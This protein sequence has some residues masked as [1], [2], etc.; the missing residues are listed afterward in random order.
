MSDD[1][2]PSPAPPSPA[3]SSGAALL[4][5]G[6]GKRS[7]AEFL[8][9]LREHGVEFL[10]D[11]RS[12]P[13]SKFK[14]EFNK[15]PLAAALR[16]A[17]IRYVFMGDAL[18][19]RPGAPECLTD[20]EV[21]YAK[22]RQQPFF[23][24]GLARLRKAYEQGR[25]VA[26]MCGEERPE[27][28]HRSRLIGAA[29]DALGLP[30]RHVD[31]NGRLLTQTQVMDRLTGGQLAL[32]VGAE[33]IAAAPPDAEPEPGAWAT[34]IPAA[35]FRAGPGES[36]ASATP[37][38]VSAAEESSAGPPPEPVDPARARVVLKQT[39]GFSGFLPL[40]AEVIE[41]LLA[42]RDTL[43]VMPTGGGKS[44]CY[45]L[46]AL[47]FDGLTVVVSPLI[48]LMQDQVRQLH[49]LGVPAAFLNSS[50]ARAEYGAIARQVRRGEARILYVAPETLLRPD[51]LELLAHGRLACFAVDEAHC[52]S[53]WGHDFRPEYRELQAV[54]RRFPRAVCVALTATATRRVRED[55]RR[56]LD[57]PE[58]GEFVASFNRANLSLAVLPR[59]D[60]LGQVLAFLEAHRQQAGIIYCATRKQVDRLAAELQERQWPALPYHAGLDPETRRRNQEQFVRA[61]DAVMVATIAFGMGINKS[62]VR[63]VLH[64]NLPK[65]LES[66]YQEIGRAGRD[67][68]PADCLLLH[69]RRDAI[70][71]RR[72]IDE[73]AAS[74][75]AGRQA[76]LEA[77]IR[78]AETTQCRRVPL[79]AYFGETHPGRCEHCDNCRSEAAPVETTDVTEAAQKFLSCV[80]RTGERFGAA[81]LIDVL[82]GSRSQRV[83]DRGHDRLSTYGIGKD[84]SATAWRELARQFI[85]QG[86]LEQDLQHG[87]LR[88]TE[89]A[90]EV[91]RGAPVRARVPTE[92][93]PTPSRR[94]AALPGH[95]AELFA[96]LR[97]LRRELADAAN[98]PPY[99]IFTDRA[100]VEMAARYPRTEAQFL[101]INGVGQAKLAH[102]GETF[103]RA[104]REYCEPRGLAPRG[105]EPP[106][107]APP[108]PSERTVWRTGEKRRQEMV[109]EQLAAGRTVTEIATELGI[110][111]ATVLKHLGA[112]LAEGHTLDPAPLWRSSPLPVTE[113]HRVLAA[114]AELGAE[115]LAPVREALGGRVSYDDLHLLRCYWLAGGTGE[116]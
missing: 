39:F 88:L 74:E 38:A 99:I 43:V 15:E 109:G 92:A 45:Q 107:P 75:A 101:E 93:A 81:H 62:N 35:E 78:Y 34:A 116:E 104:I 42:R 7:G 106:A 112:W 44:L 84:L 67:G 59:R 36:P 103:L 69:S 68:L 14:P 48:A 19:G 82:R 37:P 53:E 56:L 61:D 16:A 87:G 89:K 13:C 66:Y 73:G 70:T 80:R 108:P 50:L 20:G 51:T 79:L 40:Q 6:Y 54:R 47:L 77:M 23:Q 100:L 114:F 8:A 28:C 41:R 105:A 29:L 9:L 83:L 64:F 76:R 96:R 2:R 46:P 60:G 71:I 97:Q 102:Y 98:L 90:W 10:L 21:D 22:V 32:P 63:F 115:R 24:A 94:A 55:I 12:A 18:G 5:V 4:T 95:D 110:K 26:L 86:L 111:P 85:E 72:F 31:E 57:I 58:E 27:Q 65:D 33:E 17:G 1:V 25:R 49:E 52:I 11:V 30:V 91:F 3:A 113:R